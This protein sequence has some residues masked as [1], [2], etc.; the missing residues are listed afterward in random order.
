MFQTTGP[1]LALAVVVTLLAGLTL[2]PALLGIFGHYLF[3]PRHDRD[4]SAE[5]DRGFFARLAR[6]IARR[7]ALVTVVV[8]ALL[9]VPA[10]AVPALKQNFD[11]LAD[12]PAGSDSKVG[13]DLVAKHLDKGELMPADFRPCDIGY[14]RLGISVADFD[15]TLANLARLGTQPLTSP[16][17]APGRRRAC[18]RSPD[19]VYVEIME[20]DPLPTPA[21]RERTDCPA[22]VRAV[23]LSTP[24]LDA[25]VAY[26]TA[27]NGKGPE[28]IA[29]H[30][31]EPRAPTKLAA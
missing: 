9:V 29:L 4:V 6:L 28:E 5:A 15:A 27:L 10:M 7:P 16:L 18:V 25:S 20:D 22:A 8:L 3:W 24:D 26:F 14:T 2:A 23:T 1:A 19:G 12:L 31:A 17:G 30:T 11:V 21:G 13:F